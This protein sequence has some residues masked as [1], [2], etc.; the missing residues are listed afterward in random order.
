ML[1]LC[2]RQD[3]GHRIPCDKWERQG[4]KEAEAWWSNWLYN[5]CLKGGET[6]AGKGKPVPRDD[7]GE[8]LAWLGYLVSTNF[9]CH[10]REN[11]TMVDVLI[12]HNEMFT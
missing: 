12:S 5:V 3:V 2:P 8:P 9:S 1:K 4:A 7:S 10:H 11:S 6:E